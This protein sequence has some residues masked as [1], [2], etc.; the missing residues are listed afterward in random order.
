MTT[1]DWLSARNGGLSEGINGRSLVVTVDGEPMWRLEA[2]PAKGQ[3]T[4]AIVETNSGKRLDEGK[5]YPTRE[6]ALAGGLEELRA[7]L[8]W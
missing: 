6:A 5:E 3:L 7:K 1:L 4:C 8:G 2:V